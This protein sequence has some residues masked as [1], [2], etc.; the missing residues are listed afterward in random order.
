MT[1]RIKSGK[2][3]E[4]L[5]TIRS[6]QEKMKGKRGFVKCSL[7]RDVND[8]NLFHLIEEWET[9]HDL[10]TNIRSEEFMVLMGALKVLSEEAEVRYRMGS[11]KRGVKIY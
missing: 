10:E 8:A 4:L 1:I 2:G 11:H 3:E 7:Y 5:Q 6:L 9:P